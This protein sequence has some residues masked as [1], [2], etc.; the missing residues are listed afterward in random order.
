MA[1]VTSKGVSPSTASLTVVMVSDSTDV[2]VT[3]AVNVT[4]E[5][6]SVTVVGSALLVTSIDGSG[7]ALTK[8]QM[9]FSPGPTSMSSPRCRRCRWL[10]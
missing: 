5:P 4:F 2:L 6:G 8:V 1:V 7:A 9:T 3:S 10:P